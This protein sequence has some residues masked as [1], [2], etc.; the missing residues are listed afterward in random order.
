MRLKIAE[1][2]DIDKV[3]ELH[4]RYQ[5]DDKVVAYVMSASWQFWSTWPIFAF[6]IEDLHEIEY[7]GQKL[8]VDNSYQYGPVCVDKSVRE[9]GVLKVIF[10]SALF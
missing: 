4:Y 6:M 3:L 1:T 7:L 2:S 10:D 8:S 5:K 9:S